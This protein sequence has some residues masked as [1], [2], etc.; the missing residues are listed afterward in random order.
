MS[1]KPGQS[2]N[3]AGRPKGS[4]DKRSELRALLDPHA[5]ELVKKAVEKALEGDM[6]ALRLCLD[7]C[8]P[9]YRSVDQ[10]TQN[11]QA[12]C[13][14]QID[15]DTILNLVSYGKLDQ[16]TGLSWMQLLRQ[17]AEMTEIRSINERIK[18][19]EEVAMS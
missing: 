11:Y 6:A 16:A 2:G 15:A 7:R 13:E 8:I 17:H 10:S 12:L 19:L 1:F 9:A 5:P 14:G 3:P 18:A 4:P